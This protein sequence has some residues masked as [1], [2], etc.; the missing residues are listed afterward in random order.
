MCSY[1]QYIHVSRT[2][3]EEVKLMKMHPCVIKQLKIKLS[4]FR[5][6]I[7]SFFT[8]KVLDLEDD[9]YSRSSESPGVKRGVIL[10]Y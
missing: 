6:T 9:R 8:E 1:T 7:S 2:K 3:S 4:L 10:K 5:Y